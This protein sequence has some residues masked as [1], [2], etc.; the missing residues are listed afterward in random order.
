MKWTKGAGAWPGFWL[1]S[2]RHAT[3]PAWP[4]INPFCATNGLP[5]A[6]CGSAELDVFEGQG[7]EPSSFYGTIHRNSS[8][9]YGVAD[10]QN[11]NNWQDAGVDLTA[12]FHTYGMLWTETQITWYLD[13]RALMSAPVYDSTNQPMFLLLQMWTGGWTSDPGATTPSTI[14]TQVDYVDVWQK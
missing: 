12:D 9:G 1:L 6:L 13:G 8:G 11:A 4:G 7:S 14:E 5:A 10:R 3:N 2:Y